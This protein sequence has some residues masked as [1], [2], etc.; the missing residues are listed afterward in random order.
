MD[1]GQTKMFVDTLRDTFQAFSKLPMITIACMD[2]VCLGGG[3]ELALAC[4]FR[5]GGLGLKAGFP[6]VKLGIIPG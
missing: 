5:V 1:L 6:E 2:G 4:D 3:L